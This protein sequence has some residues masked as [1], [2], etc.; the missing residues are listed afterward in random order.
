MSVRRLCF[1]ELSE[2]R[3][4]AS[5]LEQ[6]PNSFANQYQPL[7]GDFE[8]KVNGRLERGADT[9]DFFGVYLRKGEQFT[10]NISASTED[11]FELRPPRLLL[12]SRSGTEIRST[13]ATGNRQGWSFQMSYTPLLDSVFIVGLEQQFP[14]V[15]PE[16]V[17]PWPLIEYEMSLK[18]TSKPYI[19]LVTELENNKAFISAEPK[20]PEIKWLLKG[21]VADPIEPA[22]NVINWKTT[23]DS[24]KG[25]FPHQI[26]DF[27]SITDGQSDAKSTEPYQVD[28]GTKIVGGKLEAE[29][30][31]SVRG[32]PL[33]ATTKSPASENYPK[34]DLVRVL[35]RNPT[36]ESI[37][38]FIASFPTPADFPSWQGVTYQ[39]I[40]VAIRQQESAAEHFLES[41]EPK[42]NIARRGETDD[43]G[44]GLFQITPPSIEDVWNWRENTRSADRKLRGNIPEAISYMDNIATHQRVQDFIKQNGLRPD[45]PI[46][47]LPSG[48]TREEMIVRNMIQLFNGRY[49]FRADITIDRNGNVPRSLKIAWILMPGRD[50]KYD[51]EVLERM[52]V[53]VSPLLPARRDIDSDGAIT[54]KDLVLLVEEI[55]LVFAGNAERDLGKF[56]VNSDG[57]LSPLDALWLIN[58]LNDNSRED[59]AEG[60]GVEADDSVE[61]FRKKMRRV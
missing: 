16:D 29:A 8:Y 4:F 46:T 23:L 25:T 20:M 47:V 27:K 49:A 7:N 58:W 3:M 42:F 37:D 12:L 21:F 54:L 2:R 59:L 43:G 31:V 52:G 22:T 56:D 53:L 61:S 48:I 55:N 11:S 51:E 57:F 28:F 39:R 6:E 1:E 34:Y 26:A 17:P 35:G 44:A 24:P 15:G 38:S 40:F 32:Q 50:P 19:E 30:S 18:G 5:V 33:R 9:K 41:G 60:E 14:I 36:I 13:Q 10:A 45:I